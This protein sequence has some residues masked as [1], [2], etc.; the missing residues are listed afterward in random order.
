MLIN[1]AKRIVDLHLWI[2]FA[3]VALTYQTMLFA[4]IE[5]NVAVLGVAFGGTLLCYH[6]LNLSPYIPRPQFG[7][8]KWEMIMIVAG[9]LLLLISGISIGIDLLQF[10]LIPGVL[11]ILYILPLIPSVKMNNQELKLRM[12]S[13]RSFGWYKLFLIALVWA[14]VTYLMPSLFSEHDEANSY[15][16]LL[17][18][19]LERFLFI[20]GITIPFDI[21][22]QKADPLIMRTI[23]QQFGE[24]KSIIL[25][26]FAILLSLIPLFGAA[27]LLHTPLEI[28]AAS[29]ISTLITIVIVYLSKYYRN[30]YYYTGVIDGSMYLQASL[31]LLFINI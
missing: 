12:I 9:L 13:G 21:R 22:D 20:I 31:S 18:L 16:I 24:S 3:A 27:Q 6:L 23:A 26:C 29:S 19:F 14:L 10:L 28:V 1:L 2:A 4:N 15:I 17:L 8:H 11:I 5:I 7:H 30:H 25:A